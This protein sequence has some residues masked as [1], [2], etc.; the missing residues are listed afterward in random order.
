MPRYIHVMEGGT[1]LILLIL[2]FFFFYITYLINL[3]TA[4]IGWEGASVFGVLLS[5]DSEFYS[6]H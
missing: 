2:Y 1:R 5:I 4:Y 3:H 6:Y